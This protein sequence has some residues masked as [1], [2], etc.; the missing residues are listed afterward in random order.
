MRRCGVA[1]IDLHSFT[2]NLGDGIII[3]HVH[4]SGEARRIQAAF[5]AGSL[6]T[7]IDRVR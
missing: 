6:C 5:I 3:D 4:Y 1:A 2:R 7:L